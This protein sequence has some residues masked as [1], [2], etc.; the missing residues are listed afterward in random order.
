[1]TMAS[2]GK[3]NITGICDMPVEFEYMGE[4]GVTKSGFYVSVLGQ[5][6]RK[7]Q[8]FILSLENKDRMRSFEERKRGKQE[9]FKKAE[10][11]MDDTIEA[12]AIRVSGWRGTVNGQEV[13]EYSEENAIELIKVNPI[14]RSKVIEMSNDLANFT[15]SK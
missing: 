1:M 11:D 9:S 13:P 14:I 4:D 15:K 6:S 2:F 3:L 5:Y 7:V 8:D 12:I 10:Q